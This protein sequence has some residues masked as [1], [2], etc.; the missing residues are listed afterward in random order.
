[1]NTDSRPLV[2]LRSVGPATAADLGLL[3]LCVVEDLK[4]KDAGE[5]FEA[6]CRI[7]GQRHDPCLHDVFRCAIAQAEDPDL[8]DGA[9][10]VGKDSV[11]CSGD[12]AAGQGGPDFGLAG[13][14]KI[15]EV[16]LMFIGCMQGVQSKRE[17]QLFEP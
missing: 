16:A 17:L 13:V 1:M 3:G 6:L 9:K 10:L 14:R 11:R 7:T 8:G 5:L 12:F 4:G 2:A 15:Q